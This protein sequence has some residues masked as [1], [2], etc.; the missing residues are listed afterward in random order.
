[1]RA[2]ATTLRRIDPAEFTA[3]PTI[4]GLRTLALGAAFIGSIAVGVGMLV[5]GEHGADYAARA[6][7]VGCVSGRDCHWSRRGYR[8]S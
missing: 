2:A 7:L 6:R 3:P 8:Q 1:M 4:A 5:G